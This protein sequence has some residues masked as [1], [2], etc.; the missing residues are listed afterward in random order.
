MIMLKKV[1]LIDP[2]SRT[3]GIRD[4]LIS[5]GKITKIGERLELDASLI[6]RAKG[7]VL[8]ILDCEGLCAAPGLV[9]V[10]AGWLLRYKTIW[11]DSIANAEHLSAS[12]RIARRFASRV[13]TQWPDLAQEDIVFAG[14][15]WGNNS[16]L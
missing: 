9:C 1:R 3:D 4:I 15:V 12:G 6:A 7:E 14:T 10:L 11:V 8:K 5:E 2:A 16:K 13:Y